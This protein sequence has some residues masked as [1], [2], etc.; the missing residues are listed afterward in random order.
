M[1]FLA[2]TV[3]VDDVRQPTSYSAA[4]LYCILD[5]PRYLA[6]RYIPGCAPQ[7]GELRM[8]PMRPAP[9]RYHTR[10][11]PALGRNATNIYTSPCVV[12]RGS[13]MDWTGRL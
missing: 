9:I 5:V 6:Q 4:L 10:T 13:A 12:R 1:Y 7:L 2:P 11:T 3:W 8:G